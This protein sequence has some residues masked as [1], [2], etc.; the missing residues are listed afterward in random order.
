MCYDKFIESNNIK[1][2]LELGCGQGRDALYFATKGFQIYALDS[3]KIGIESINS[4]AKESGLS[5]IKI[6]NGMQNKDCHLIMIISRQSI[7]ICSL[8]WDSSIRIYKI[9]SKKLTEL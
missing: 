1:S 9:C 3:S 7:R 6:K 8:I 5:S 2:I 4:K